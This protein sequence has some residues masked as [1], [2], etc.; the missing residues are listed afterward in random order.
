M[1][2][3]RHSNSSSRKREPEHT[4]YGDE[5]DARSY[6]HLI[7]GSGQPQDVQVPRESS[8]DGSHSSSRRRKSKKQKSH[9]TRSRERERERPNMDNPGKSLV[10]AYDD[11][12][13]DSDIADKVI[14]REPARSPS[15]R[16]GPSRVGGKNKNRRSISPATLIR[17]YANARSLSNSPNLRDPSPYRNDISS[18]RQKS[19]KRRQYSPEI[20]KQYSSSNSRM[21][22]EPP[23]AYADLPKAYSSGPRALSPSP[24][25]NSKRYRSRSRSPLHVKRRERGRSPSLGNSK[26]NRN[27]YESPVNREKYSNRRSR[28]RSRNKYAHSS[29]YSISPSPS[30]EPARRSTTNRNSS[31]SQSTVKYASSLAA[32]ISKH[33]RARALRNDRLQDNKRPYKETVNDKHSSRDPIVISPSPPRILVKESMKERISVQVQ[34][35]NSQ[36]RVIE[37]R[38]IEERRI[39]ERRIEERR[40]E[41]RRIED[42]RLEERR[43]EERHTEDRRIDERRNEERRN[44]D[45]NNDRRNEYEERKV[46]RHVNVRPDSNEDI[47]RSPPPARKPLPLPQVTPESSS[48]PYSDRSRSREPSPRRRRITDLPMPPNVDD[49]EFDD[50]QEYIQDLDGDKKDQPKIKRPRMCLLRRYNDKG[51]GDWGERSVDVFKILEIIGEGT[52]GQVYKARDTYTD[53]YVALKKVRLENEKEGFP[54]TAVREIKILRQLNHPNI[55]N[56]KEIVTDK[57]DAM[58]FKKDKGAFYLVFEYMDHDLMGLL[59][60]GFVAFREENIASFMKQLLDGLHYCH[61]MNFLHRDIKCSNI[62]L[63]NKGQIKLADLGLAR[64]YN[65]EDKDRLYTNKVITLWYRPPELLLGEERYGPAID[66]WSLG[67]ILGELFTRKPIFQANQEFPQLELIS[68]TCGSPCPANWPDVIKLP[69]FH[70]FKPKRQYRRRLREEFSF[71]PKSALDLMDR[72]L[73]LD[74]SKRCTAVEGLASP[75]LR[76]VN[77]DRIPPPDLPK[78]QDCHE[79]WCKNRKKLMREAL[80]RGDDSF[81]KSPLR[82]SAP[83]GQQNKTF[84]AQTGD[85]VGHYEKASSVSSVDFKNKLGNVNTDMAMQDVNSTLVKNQLAQLMP[86]LE[87]QTSLSVAQIAKRLDVNIDPTTSQ[88]LDNLKNQMLASSALQNKQSENTGYGNYGSNGNYSSAG[89]GNGFGQ[90]KAFTDQSAPPVDKNAGV[91]AALMQLLSGGSAGAGGIATQR[92]VDRQYSE[93]SD[94]R[95][96]HSGQFSD[97]PAATKPTIIGQ[98]PDRKALVPPQKSYSSDD[99]SDGLKYGGRHGQPQGSGEPVPLR[100][101]VQSYFDQYGGSGRGKPRGGYSGG[102]GGAGGNPR[103]GYGGGSRGRGQ[104]WR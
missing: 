8:R 16:T 74:P 63:N 99:S 23:R 58:D 29:R 25:R 79:L 88:L 92:S 27:R 11:I 78:D 60:S 97:Y 50:E 61:S 82:G 4:F 46:E 35:N 5:F 37:D 91:K 52:Y 86:L 76:D 54:I 66:V 18:K 26:R 7:P 24:P 103:G 83:P 56:L 22:A 15:S 12:S 34:N 55:V 75:W 53:D 21:P 70:T 94:S 13:S 31:I 73:D 102:Y 59:E 19:S 69:L 57:Q 80:K 51:K 3:H 10:Q 44:D 2:K 89:N 38:R 100:A 28:S 14:Q 77:P 45:R 41:E 32:E 81:S 47:R 43:I 101:K 72:M 20:E 6:A 30:P 49:P 65:A 90:T 62:L 95:L 104:S 87:G 67:C 9:K 40:L 1:P 33:K 39:E 93:G 96:S 85:R 36:E 71:M 98:P 64:Y 17:S 84:P 68:K 48:S 42:R